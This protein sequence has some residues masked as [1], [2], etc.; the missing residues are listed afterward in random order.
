MAAIVSNQKQCHQCKITDAK[1][2]T[3]SLKTCSGCKV[4]HYCSAECQGKDWP[5]H[6]PLC[7]KVISSKVHMYKGLSEIPK[8]GTMRFIPEELQ[9]PYFL[10]KHSDKMKNT[11]PSKE[12][13]SIQDQNEISQFLEEYNGEKILDSTK[14][15]NFR[16]SLLKEGKFHVLINWLGKVIK[17]LPHPTF[18]L[19]FSTTLFKM[20]NRNMCQPSQKDDF[21]AKSKALREIAMAFIRVD[22]KCITNDPSCE[23]SVE[24]FE[25]KCLVNQLSKVQKTKY[26]RFLKKEV[27]KLLLLLDKCPSPIWIGFQGR[28]YYMGIIPEIKSPAECKLAREKEL[29]KLLEKLSGHL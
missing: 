18:Y 29:R 20:A 17:D 9:S 19:N 13:V 10:K 4:V 25:A 22:V 12:N 7:K 11:V 27:N 14:Y 5:V 8:E 26:K 16:D 24:D 21:F 23:E 2:P 1:L 6:Q 3:G 15:A 28:K